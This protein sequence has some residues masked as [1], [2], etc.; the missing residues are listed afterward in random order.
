MTKPATIPPFPPTRVPLSPDAR[1]TKALFPHVPHLSLAERDRR[2]DQLRKKMLLAG[3]DA[4]VFFGNDI[5]WGQGMGN[6][7]YVFGFDSNSGGYGLLPLDGEAT[8]WYGLPHMNRPTSIANAVQ[9]WTDDIRDAGGVAA[10][11][12]ELRRRGLDRGRLGLVS[13]GSTTLPGGTLLHSEL[14]AMEHHLPDATLVPAT[15]MLT[16][17]RLV[18]SDE[19]IGM[20]RRAGRIARKVVDAMV[21]SVRPGVTEAE[22]YA[23]MIRTQIAN[24]AEP[25][26]FN[27]LASGPVDHPGEELWHLLHGVEQPGSPTTRPIEPGDLVIAEFHTRYAGYRCHTEYTV[28]FGERVP[29]PIQRIWEVSV[30]TLEV[31]Q[32]ALTAGRTLREAWQMIREPAKRARL[33]FVELGF[34]AMGLGSP[35]FPTVIYEEGFGGNIFN[36]DQIGDFVLEQ[37]MAFGNNID[38]HDSTWKPD[39]GCMLADFMIVRPDRA[40]CLVNTPRELGHVRP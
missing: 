37:G 17:M 12:A 10:I 40:E 29:A 14:E 31:S 7:R 39:V 6:I 8:I 28:Y 1:A 16:E 2:R 5:Y 3:L 18:K 13:Y 30:E 33:D 35:E 36:G 27:M 9:D 15:N 20:L 25:N 23:E 21:E 24:G 11:A 26:V 38:L 34:H 19:E 22:V 4:L 32:Q